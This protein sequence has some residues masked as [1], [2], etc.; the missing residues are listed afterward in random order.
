[1]LLIKFGIFSPPNQAWD[2]TC[3]S[4]LCGVP[5]YTFSMILWDILSVIGHT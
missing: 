3:D 1:M 2:S 4:A 5:Q